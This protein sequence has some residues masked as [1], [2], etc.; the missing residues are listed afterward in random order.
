[1]TT[2]TN[3]YDSHTTMT[4]E[5]I[6]THNDDSDDRL[7]VEYDDWCE[8][9]DLFIGW[10]IVNPQNEQKLIDA[11]VPVD[12]VSELELEKELSDTSNYHDWNSELASAQEKIKE[13]C[14][15]ADG[16][17]VDGDEIN[18]ILTKLQSYI[19]SVRT[20]YGNEITSNY[21]VRI[22]DNEI[23]VDQFTRDA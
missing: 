20:K 10:N 23:I 16:D 19:V 2:P 11:R 17:E 12:M 14:D 13:I 8:L 4:L 22:E 5:A 9:T 3:W 15:D 6:N 18:E 7:Y 21:S 1:M